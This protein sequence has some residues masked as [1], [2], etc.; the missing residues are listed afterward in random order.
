MAH[1][2]QA[3]EHRCVS[4]GRFRSGLTTETSTILN[5]RGPCQNGADERFHDQFGDEYLSLEGFAHAVRLAVLRVHQEHPVILR[6]LGDH[7]FE[8]GIL[9]L[10]FYVMSQL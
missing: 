9:G 8:F 10:S 6:S 7:P 3:L 5:A 1:D 2:V 4:V